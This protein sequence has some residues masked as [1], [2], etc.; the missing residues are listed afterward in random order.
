MDFGY[1]V[2]F[3]TDTLA[4]GG[5]ERELALLIKYL[6]HEWERIIWSTGDGPFSNIIR[7]TG[8]EI[9]IDKRKYHYDI[10]PFFRLWKIIGAKRP[11]IIHSWSWMSTFAAGPIC[12]AMNIPLIDSTIQSG[13]KLSK[14]NLI[15]VRWADRVIANSQA[16]LQASGIDPKRARVVYNGIDP[17]R[18][19]LCQNH[20]LLI[21][22]AFKVVMTGRMV[23]EKDFTTLLSAAR[24]VSGK[25]PDLWQFFAIGYG[26]DRESLITTSKD[27]L[28]R[29]CI[30]FPEAG[31]E[32]LTYVRQANVGVLLTNPMYHAEGCS[33]SIMEYMACGLPVICTQNGGNGELVTDG[34]TGFLINPGDADGLAERLNYLRENPEIARKMGNCGKER[35]LKDFTLEKMVYEETHVYQE[36]LAK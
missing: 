4:L 12:K 2:L 17:E 1:K 6:P 7:E 29:G 32:V 25:N 19:K 34:E 9:H 8:A 15:A 10:T 28:D 22:G 36:M 20:Q 26:P 33:N 27:L 24:A 31:L 16:G 3:L 5:A 21:P 35:L 18:L 14:R 11:D 23:R 13:M 30:A